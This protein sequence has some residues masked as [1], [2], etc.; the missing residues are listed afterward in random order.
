[1]GGGGVLLWCDVEVGPGGGQLVQPQPL[2]SGGLQGQPGAVRG[3]R[4]RT[5]V[6]EEVGGGGRDRDGV[7]FGE[8]AV[9]GGEG[10]A[11]VGF[12]VGGGGPDQQRGGDVGGAGEFG[13]VVEFA[14]D[15]AGVFAAEVV[16]EEE[17]EAVAAVG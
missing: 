13:V 8:V 1:G 3:A 11:E 5:E 15:L 4:G 6:V 17:V 7:W 10:V 2:G 14:G 16:F 9:G 12:S